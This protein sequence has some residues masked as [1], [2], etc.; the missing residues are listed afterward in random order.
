LLLHILTIWTLKAI[1]RSK[2]PRSVAALEG[3]RFFC[4]LGAVT[5]LAKNI[6]YCCSPYCPL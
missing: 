2:K 1:Q 5:V 3:S 4:L 6:V